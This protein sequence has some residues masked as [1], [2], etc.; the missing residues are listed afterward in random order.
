[1]SGVASL[2]ERRPEVLEVRT[3]ADRLIRETAGI[4][5]HIACIA[6]VEAAVKILTAASGISIVVALEG[7][8][9]TIGH[10]LSIERERGGG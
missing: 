1:M 2:D 6:C 4:R 5:T 9:T 7:L 3:V 8:Q 10:M